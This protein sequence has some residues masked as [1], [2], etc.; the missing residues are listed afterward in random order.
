MERHPALPDRDEVDRVGE[1]VGEVVLRDDVGD[2]EDHA[3][4]DQHADQRV[5]QEVLDLIGGQPEPAPSGR[6]F[7]HRKTQMK[8]NR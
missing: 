4:A 2:H 6:R 7:I 5:D 3:A 1:V 8:P